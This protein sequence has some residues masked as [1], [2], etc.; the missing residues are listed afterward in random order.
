VVTGPVLDGGGVEEHEAD[1]SSTA[2]K[3]RAAADFNMIGGLDFIGFTIYVLKKAH[4][5]SKSFSLLQRYRRCLGNYSGLCHRQRKIVPAPAA[6]CSRSIRDL[7]EFI[8]VG[9]GDLLGGGVMYRTES[10]LTQKIKQ[11]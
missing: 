3:Q 6:A 5:A 9:S 1:A 11:E 8:G 4:P 10:P 2:V 7:S